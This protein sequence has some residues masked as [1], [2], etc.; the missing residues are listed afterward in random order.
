MRIIVNYNEAKNAI[1]E[2]VNRQMVGSPCKPENVQYRMTIATPK[3]KKLKP[4][5]VPE[6]IIT[7]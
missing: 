1:A 3:Y 5:P 4:I 7:I 6:F 2:H